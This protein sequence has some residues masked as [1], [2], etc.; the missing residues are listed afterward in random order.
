[1]RLTQPNSNIHAYHMEDKL[2]DISCDFKK[3]CIFAVLTYH[4]IKNNSHWFT[5]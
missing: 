2:S 1:M 4:R 3:K 5:E